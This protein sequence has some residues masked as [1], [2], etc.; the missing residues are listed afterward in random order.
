MH[1]DC[2]RASTGRNT[3]CNACGVKFANALRKIVGVGAGE[4]VS[5]PSEPAK[6]VRKRQTQ[7]VVTTE[8]H[9]K[10]KVCMGCMN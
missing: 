8:K 2:H 1:A 4:Y 7:H 10:F 6:I 5:G 9:K 3:L